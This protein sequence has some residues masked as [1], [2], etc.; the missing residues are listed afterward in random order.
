MGKN[1]KSKRFVQQGSDAV[2][3]HAERFP[4]RST[5]TEAERKQEEAEEQNVGGF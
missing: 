2:K 3:Q 5:F 1:S 4:Y